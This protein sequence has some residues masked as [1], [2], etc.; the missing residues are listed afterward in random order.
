M[1][2]GGAYLQPRLCRVGGLQSWPRLSRALKIKN[3][4]ARIVDEE[5]AA[6][7]GPK[8]GQPGYQKRIGEV[9]GQMRRDRRASP[10]EREAELAQKRA[11]TAKTEADTEYVRAKILKSEQSGN[12]AETGKDLSLE[13]DR[14]GRVAKQW[15]ENTDPTISVEE[16]QGKVHEYQNLQDQL[17]EQARKL[18]P[19]RTPEPPKTPPEKP[20]SLREKLFG[21]GASAKPPAAASGDRETRRVNALSRAQALA[22]ELRGQ[23]QGDALKAEIKKRLLA[24]GVNPDEL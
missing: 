7:K 23:F 20:K 3:Q 1:G 12:K 16:K 21:G 8:D 5:A 13:A 11:R 14:W 18:L 2:T 9:L 4:A 6:G 17:R 19:P 15:Q 22:K 10:E 24:E